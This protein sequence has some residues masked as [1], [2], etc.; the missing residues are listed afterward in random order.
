[1]DK[2][3]RQRYAHELLTSEAWKLIESI[4]DRA[5]V[6][7]LQGYSEEKFYRYRSLQDMKDELTNELLNQTPA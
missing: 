2:D 1:M 7:T 5:K 4:I 3:L 6:N